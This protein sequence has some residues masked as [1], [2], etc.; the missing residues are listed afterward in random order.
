MHIY[1]G[2]ELRNELVAEAAVW[3]AIHPSSASC[4]HAWRACVWSQRVCRKSTLAS[5]APVYLNAPTNT[6]LS[7]LLNDGKGNLSL[8]STP[9]VGSGP[10]GIALA[11][12]FGTHKLGVAEAN[13]SGTSVEV[14]AQP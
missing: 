6:Y 14:L 13:I 11:D 10:V 3:S 4:L 5:F 7:V 2:Q 1:S 9:T 8:S 12:F